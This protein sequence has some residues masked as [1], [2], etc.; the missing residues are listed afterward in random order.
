LQRKDAIRIKVTANIDKQYG[1]MK[2]DIC[3]CLTECRSTVE[4]LYPKFCSID[5]HLSTEDDNDNY[6]VCVQ[7]LYYDLYL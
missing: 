5:E 1:L 6:R 7:V 2:D 3:R 4:L